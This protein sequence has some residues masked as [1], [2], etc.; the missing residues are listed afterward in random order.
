MRMTT[1][2]ITETCRSFADFDA[3]TRDAGIDI[4]RGRAGARL[5]QRVVLAGGSPP[6]RR[7]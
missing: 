6:S 1:K 2:K 5:V 7:R 3:C 4:R